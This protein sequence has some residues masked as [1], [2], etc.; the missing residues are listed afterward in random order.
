M[1]RIFV[2]VTFYLTYFVLVYK[3][4]VFSKQVYKRCVH[5]VISPKVIHYCFMKYP[6]PIFGRIRYIGRTDNDNTI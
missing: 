5:E 1:N 6:L 3:L 4:S 2:I